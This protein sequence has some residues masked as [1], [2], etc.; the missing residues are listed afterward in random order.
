[1]RRIRVL[2]L[3]VLATIFWVACTVLT[4]GC[5]TVRE[6]E[7]I[8]GTGAKDSESETGKP[9]SVEPTKKIGSVREKFFHDDGI[10]YGEVSWRTAQY[11]NV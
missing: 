7:E 11:C 1:M 9:S 4:A 10:Y 3:I 8:R 5:R 6:S 2:R